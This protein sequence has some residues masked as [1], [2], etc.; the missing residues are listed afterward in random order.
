MRKE[1][2]KYLCKK[3]KASYFS[4]SKEANRSQASHG[5]CHPDPLKK[6]PPSNHYHLLQEIMKK[7]QVRTHPNSYK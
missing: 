3:E 1:R 4:F 2:K 7:E 6:P 5:L